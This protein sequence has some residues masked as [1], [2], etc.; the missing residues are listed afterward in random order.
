MNVCDRIR[1]LRK[2]KKFTLTEV[3]DKLKNYFGEDN[4]LSVPYLSEVERGISTPSIKTLEKLAKVFDLSLSELLSGVE[5]EKEELDTKLKKIP[6]KSQYTFKEFLK[7][8]KTMDK[9]ELDE[10]WINTLLKIEYRGKHPESVEGWL[11]I[12]R[13]LKTSLNDRH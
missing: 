12:Y 5:F 11:D 6:E 1:E 4:A 13:A 7:L 8:V 2:E 9:V 3:R 10:S